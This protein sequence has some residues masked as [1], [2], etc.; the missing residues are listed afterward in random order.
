MRTP[1][2]RRI[3]DALVG[4]AHETLCA[5]GAACVRPDGAFYL[6]PDFSAL[7][8]TLRPR[9]IESSEDLADAL[10]RCEGVAL[11]PGAAFGRPPSELSL[12]LSLVD[13]DGG[14]AMAAEAAGAA[15]DRAFLAEYCRGCVEAV[16][17][18]AAFVAG[19]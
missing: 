1:V 17:R 10:L 19:P 5:A 2:A 16:D 8:E 11:L 13:F 14:R 9:G 3:L 6:F 4:H 7:A 12:R 18:I 15:I